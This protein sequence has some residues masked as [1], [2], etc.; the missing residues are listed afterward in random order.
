[1]QTRKNFQLIYSQEISEYFEYMEDYPYTVQERD[2]AVWRHHANLLTLKSGADSY[3][4][5]S[6]ILG[7]KLPQLRGQ[8]M[9]LV[10]FDT[11]KDTHSSI[12][13]HFIFASL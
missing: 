6:T 12:L 11:K 7:H 3:S 4:Q 1:M 9:Y 13:C 10:R 2:S 8:H 5:A